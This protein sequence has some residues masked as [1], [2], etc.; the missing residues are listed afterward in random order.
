MCLVICSG[1]K[2]SIPE[3]ALLYCVITVLK[4]TAHSILFKYLP[5]QMKTNCHE[6][7]QVGCFLSKSENHWNHWTL[8]MK[9]KKNKKMCIFI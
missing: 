8:F 1:L 5:K 6:K 3:Q 2:D 7:F 4:N 9:G